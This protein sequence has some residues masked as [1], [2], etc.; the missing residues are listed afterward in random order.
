MGRRSIYTPE[1]ANEIIERIS[2]GEPLKAICRDEHMPTWSVVYRWIRDI[3]DFA[4]EMNIARDMGADAIA[5][6]AL[7]IADTPVVGEETEES[8][9]GRKVRR[10]D[11][12]GHRKLQVET[13]LKLLAKWHPK[14]YGDRTAMEL[15]GADGGPV[16]IT[17]TERAAKIAAILA[18]AKAR[19]DMESDD[20]AD[21]L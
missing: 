20:V 1:L 15:T 18:A 14:K 11:M 9:T 16:R 8:E 12:L 2:N 13:R 5:E 4:T 7:S 6:E 17:D 3:P 19:R 21:L 10:G